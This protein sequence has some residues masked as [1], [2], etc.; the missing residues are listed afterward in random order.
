M[1]HMSNGTKF[2]DPLSSITGNGLD[3]ALLIP[4]HDEYVNEARYILDQYVTELGNVA[5]KFEVWNEAE[6]VSGF[7]AKVSRKASRHKENVRDALTLINQAVHDVQEKFTNYFW[8]GLECY[9]D[10]ELEWYSILK[11][12]AWYR[13]AYEQSFE[14]EHPPYLSFAWL[15]IKPMCQLKKLALAGL[16]TSYS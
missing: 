6:L 11:A 10:E 1:Y 13:V 8:S 9:S 2:S 5:V 12:S 3:K 14:H 4:G 7:I 15:P 16:T